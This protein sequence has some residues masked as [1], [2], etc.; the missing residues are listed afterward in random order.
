MVWVNVS[1]TGI[2]IMGDN[3]VGAWVEARTRLTDTPT[4]R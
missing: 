2:F 3:V 4:L 1:M